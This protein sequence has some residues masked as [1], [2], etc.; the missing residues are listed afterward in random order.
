MSRKAARANRTLLLL[1]HGRPALRVIGAEQVHGTGV[2]VV[3]GS[4]PDD[5]DGVDALVAAQPGS[6]LLVVAADCMPV[7]FADVEAGVVAAAH[8]GRPGLVA[9]VL[10]A[11]V[12][13]MVGQGADPTRVTAVV[14]PSICGRCYELPAAMVGELDE[15]LPGLAATTSWG[16]PSIDLRTGAG[17]AL[18]EVGVADVRHVGGCTF[19][20]PERFFSYRRDGTTARHGGLVA[21]TGSAR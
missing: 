18:A 20:Q 19:E 4:T 12:T 6:A 21:L 14:G 13:A 7:L 8:A 16:T 11:T 2:A 17:L 5:V 1:E 9:G 10:Q 3:T 15:R